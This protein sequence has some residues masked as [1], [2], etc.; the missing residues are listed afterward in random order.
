[1]LFLKSHF[2]CSVDD[3]IDITKHESNIVKCDPEG[4]VEL[5]IFKKLRS[6]C[7]MD[8]LYFPFDEQTCRIQFLHTVRVRT[9]LQGN[10]IVEEGISYYVVSENV[11]REFLLVN[12]QWD[13]LDI[14]MN[15]ASVTISPFSPDTVVTYPAFE[16]VLHLRRKPSFYFV[17]L[18]IPGTV[19]AMIC[20]MGFL[21]PNESGEKVSLQLTAFLSLMVLILVV[22]DIIPPVGE[23]FPFIGNTS[24][25]HLK[26]E[27]LV[28]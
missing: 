27:F 10:L 15:N 24:K 5:S 4:R 2:R 12:E 21:L 1:M 7:Q 16:I 14:T 28:I 13:L 9:T 23:R 8:L 26:F 19:I 6:F 18:V 20:V 22:V 11:S 17:V 3:G 25:V